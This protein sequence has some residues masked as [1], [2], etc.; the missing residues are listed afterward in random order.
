VELGGGWAVIRS[1]ARSLFNTLKAANRRAT[2]KGVVSADDKYSLYLLRRARKQHP[3]FM[4]VLSKLCEWDLP[5]LYQ[6]GHDYELTKES[7]MTLLRQERERLTEIARGN[8]ERYLG[9][10]APSED[11]IYDEA[12]NLA[13]DALHDAGVDDAL[14]REVAGEVAQCYA[15]P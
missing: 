2:V 14:A 13:F 10:V 4:E 3:I 12:Y 15:Q 6:R 9:D 8:V 7:E 5:L 1:K 11:A